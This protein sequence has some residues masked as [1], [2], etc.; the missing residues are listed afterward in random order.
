LDAAAHEV[1]SRSRAVCS[2]IGTAQRLKRMAAR[3][4]MCLRTLPALCRGG[5][6][7]ADGRELE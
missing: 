1:K 2:G 4:M 7:F 6:D 3:L 5:L